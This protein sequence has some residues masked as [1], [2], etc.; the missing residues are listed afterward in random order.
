MVDKTTM[1]ILALYHPLRPFYFLFLGRILLPPLLVIKE[2][3]QEKREREGAYTLGS[4]AF[5]LPP[6][7]LRLR[8]RS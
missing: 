1:C 2:E 7:T 6:F 3:M 8:A 4:R 5:F